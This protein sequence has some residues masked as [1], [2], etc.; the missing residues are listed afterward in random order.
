MEPTATPELVREMATPKTGVAEGVR[1]G[2]IVGLDGSD[3]VGEF[4]GDTVCEGRMTRAGMAR[5]AASTSSANEKPNK[6]ADP[7]AASAVTR[8]PSLRIARASASARAAADAAPMGDAVTVDV[9]VNVADDEIDTVELGDG[10]FEGVAESV[11]GAV[12]DT[13][14]P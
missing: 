11:R 4:V 7:L 13:D 6:G 5:S 8:R 3:A 10:V 12:L 1:A 14:E 2:V 9:G